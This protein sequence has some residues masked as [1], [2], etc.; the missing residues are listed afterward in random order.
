VRRIRLTWASFVVA[1]VL[2]APLVAQQPIPLS[3]SDAIGFDY[4]DANLTAYQVSGFEASYDSGPWVSL[5]IPTGVIL[6][7][8]PAGSRTYKAIPPF[9][10]GTHT[11]VFRACNGAGCGV[12]SSPFAF[13]HVS[14]PG[15]SPGNVR[16]VPR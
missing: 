11:V 9:T 12:P 14:S 10:S 3:P 7:D 2:V 4:T 16:K 1:F 6:P 5:G 13:E 15:A 8:T